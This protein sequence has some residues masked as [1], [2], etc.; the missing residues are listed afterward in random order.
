MIGFFQYLMSKNNRLLFSILLVL[1]V[2]SFVLYTGSGSVM[3]LMGIRKSEVVFGVKMKDAEGKP[4]RQLLSMMGAENQSK[5]Q[6]VQTFA[7]LVYIAKLADEL[8][9]PN[10]NEDEFTQTYKSMFGGANAQQ[11]AQILARFNID[12]NELKDLIVLN[13]RVN[14]TL[15]LLAGTPSS[16]PE[17]TELMM[18]RANTRWT[19]EVARGNAKAFAFDAEPSAEELQTYFNANARDYLVPPQLHLAYAI[20]EPSEAERKAV[21]DPDEA[22]L[23]MF[24]QGQSD[25][26][27]KALKEDHATWVKRWKQDRIAVELASRTSDLLAEKLPQDVV[28]P[29]NE[30]FAKSLEN[31][32]LKFVDLPVFSKGTDAPTSAVPAEI[33]NSMEETLNAT[34]WRSDAIPMGEKAV[35]VVYKGEDPARVPAIDEVRAQVI[36]NWKIATKEAKFLEKMYEQGKAL[37][38]AVKNGKDFIAT[39]TELGLKPERTLP[40]SE[41]NVPAS[42][43][44]S[45][46]PVLDVLR[47]IPQGEIST[48]LRCGD[49]V[50]YV[51]AIAKDVPAVDKNSNEYLRMSAYIERVFASNSL[52]VQMQERIFEE[53]EK[54]GL[55]NISD[56]E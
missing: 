39:A 32:G 36:A 33:M 48:A 43:A 47:A 25:D 51:R 19:V 37:V 14:K 38:E 40:F 27:E 17:M 22:E 18:R 31:S 11:Q 53:L 1:I 10:P 21:P 30:D 4:Y 12:E 26:V 44:E 13:Y 55:L 28:S 24:V 9:V 16:F 42:L 23:K 49:D 20:V 6:Y 46:V 45:S 50:I 29:T 34:L 2:F 8:Q 56:E 54:R 35:V 52:S 15:E 5:R 41:N 7:Q 3:D